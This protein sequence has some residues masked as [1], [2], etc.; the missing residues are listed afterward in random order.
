MKFDEVRLFFSVLD[1]REKVI[2][3]LAV[4]AGMRPGEILALRR[5]QLEEGYADITQ[6][7]YRG[8][9][10]TPKTFNSRRWAALGSGLE[11]WIRGWLEM[12]PD[13]SSE[14]WVFP[15]RRQAP[16]LFLEIT[17]GGTP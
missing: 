9:L 4:L 7:I 12:I 14:A 8:Q 11:S 16:P 2:G 15:F 1:L 3:G 10:D 6:R 13:E 5:A 17:A